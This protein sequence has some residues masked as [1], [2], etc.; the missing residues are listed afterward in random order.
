MAQSISG[1]EEN[2]SHVV[3]G[4]DVSLDQKVEERIDDAESHVP[5]LT[6]AKIR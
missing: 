2:S 4:K 6:A 1:S 5:G 3:L